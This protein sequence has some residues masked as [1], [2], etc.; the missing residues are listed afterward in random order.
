MVSHATYINSNFS[1]LPFFHVLLFFA[2]FVLLQCEQLMVPT[3]LARSYQNQI[4]IGILHVIL[5]LKLGPT[6]HC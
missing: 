6:C 2:T 3:E 5:L 1:V 4:S